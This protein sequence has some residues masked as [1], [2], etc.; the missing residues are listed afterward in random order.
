MNKRNKAFTA[1]LL[2]ISLLSI[3]IL[4]GCGS[5]SAAI[6]DSRPRE[7]VSGIM[8]TAAT[9]PIYDWVR[10]I[11]KD[12]PAD[13]SVDL[14][15]KDQADLHNYQPSANDI[16]KVRASDLFIYIGGESDEWA[17]DIIEEDFAAGLD[18]KTISLMD[19]MDGRLKEEE[20]KEGMEA[21]EE[22]EEE[23][24]GPEYDEHIWLSLKNASYLVQMISDKIQELD[25]DNAELYKSNTSDYL[26]KLNN[27]DERYE[28]V[29][30]LA[31]EKTLLFGDRFPF[32]YLADDYDLDYYAA[33]VGCSA[34]T[35]ASFGTIIFLAGKADELG[36]K[37][38][39]V[40]ENSDKKI[41]EAVIEN[42]KTKDQ[43]ILT[44]NSLQSVPVSDIDA[45][46]TYLGIMEENL[47]VLKKALDWQEK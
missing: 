46:M 22:E 26:N 45:G 11:T 15:L 29:T 47:D 28:A 7:N 31:E 33:F 41:A 32:R 38:V 39:M 34:E 18:S 17:E 43:D 42:T 9:F 4:S 13:I 40:I 21:E 35:E 1:L 37:H 25:P 27:L 16:L 2:T 19:L 14:L 24:G 36:L 10:V 44:L 5:S 30:S 12:T 3:S 8:I 23:E 20:I 6:E